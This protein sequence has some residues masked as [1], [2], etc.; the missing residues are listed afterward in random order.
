MNRKGMHALV[1][2][3]RYQ[4]INQAVALNEALVGKGFTNRNDLKMA[5]CA[6]GH[7]VSMTF[8]KHL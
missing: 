7:M 6:S 5:L 1:K 4:F 2:F 8:V 3:V